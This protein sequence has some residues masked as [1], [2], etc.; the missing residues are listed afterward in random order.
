MSDAAKRKDG[1]L[2][3]VLNKDA[4]EHNIDQGSKGVDGIRIG[5]AVSMAAFA[6]DDDDE[7]DDDDQANAEASGAAFWLSRSVPLNLC[8]VTRRWFQ[9]HLAPWSHLQFLEARIGPKS[10]HA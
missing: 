4:E 5:A 2:M 3:R 10:S 8:F 6:D 1:T 7:E 9:S